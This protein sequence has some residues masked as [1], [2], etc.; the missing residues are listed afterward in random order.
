MRKDKRQEELGKL[1][2]EIGD[3]ASKIDSEMDEISFATDEIFNRLRVIDDLL[4]DCGGMT[5]EDVM[6]MIKLYRRMRQAQ[7]EGD[8]VLVDFI[9]GQIDALVE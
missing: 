9:L 3:F 5:V 1:T 8:S 6:R 4:A 2:D 7:K